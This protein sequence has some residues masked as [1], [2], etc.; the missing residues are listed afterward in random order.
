MSTRDI[1]AL[2]LELLCSFCVLR[3]HRSKGL[4]F[5]ISAHNADIDEMSRYASFSSQTS[6]CAKV[7][8]QGFLVYKWSGTISM[9]IT[10]ESIVNKRMS[11]S[12]ITL[13]SFGKNGAKIERLK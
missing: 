6:L 2:S 7:P 9:L 3:G 1:Y 12:F 10:E 11:I 5:D 8:V 13:T 4:N